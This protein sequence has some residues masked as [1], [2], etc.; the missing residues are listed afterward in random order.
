MPN[1]PPKRGSAFS[2]A[3]TLGLL[4]LLVWGISPRRMRIKPAPLEP[5]T[6]VCP[7][8]KAEFVPSNFTEV[9]G[10]P[11]EALPDRVKNRILLRL[12]MEPCTC[13]CSQSLASCRASNPQCPVSPGAIGALVKDEEGSDAPT[14]G[15][16][17]PHR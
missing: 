9:P 5:A 8:S 3:I 1:Q 13:G 16:V 10:A 17:S 11:I 6:A 2:V 15:P 7:P 4:A 12:N 14:H